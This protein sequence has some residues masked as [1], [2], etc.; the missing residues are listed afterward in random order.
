MIIWLNGAFGAGKTT[1]AT[2]LVTLVPGSRLFDTEQ[3]GYMLRHVLAD[4]VVRD[5]QDWAPWRGLVVAAATQILD[6]IGGVLVVAQ[7]VLVEQY[8]CE[9]RAGLDTAGI[10][11][12]HYV[13]DAERGELVRRIG[14]DAA[15]PASIWRHE[16]L[17]DYAAARAWHA[18]HARVIDTTDR[19]AHD[20]ATL[21]AGETAS[22]ATTQRVRR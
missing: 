2:E 21:I 17:P 14:T 5:F 11:V 15:D 12:R 10:A 6:H 1:T 4:E 7:S 8:W 3:V 19:A 16:R 9:I 22:D 20:V 18:R 13:L